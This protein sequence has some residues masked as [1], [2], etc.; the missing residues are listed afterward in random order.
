MAQQMTLRYNYPLSYSIGKIIGS[1]RPKNLRTEHQRLM[2]V[3]EQSP[4]ILKRNLEKAG[5][6]VKVFLRHDKPIG[7]SP[8]EWLH[9]FLHAIPP[10]N[11]FFVTIFGGL[12]QNEG[13]A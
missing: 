3:T 13:Q 5:F 6:Q 7:L 2:H 1:T 8:A 11:W 10:L 4:T 9:Y 12:E